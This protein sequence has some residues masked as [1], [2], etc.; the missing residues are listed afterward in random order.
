M[1]R[2]SGIDSRLKQT[3]PVAD[4]L[5]MKAGSYWGEKRSRTCAQGPEPLPSY[6]AAA[7]FVAD[8]SDNRDT[9]VEAIA[10]H[11]RCTGWG[12]GVI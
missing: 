10:R 12:Y 11:F 1:S 6:D 9:R 4:L 3:S 7:V 8:N 2:N 5:G